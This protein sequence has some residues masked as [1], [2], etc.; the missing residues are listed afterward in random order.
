MSKIMV[1]C[2]CDAGD[3][4]PQGRCGAMRRCSILRDERI[5]PT[6][7]LLDEDTLKTQDRAIGILDERVDNLEK[8]CEALQGRIEAVERTRG[9]FTSLLGLLGYEIGDFGRV[10]P[11]RQEASIKRI[12]KGGWANV[13]VDRGGKLHIGYAWLTKAEAD[14]LAAGRIACIQIPDITE[15]DGL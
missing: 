6:I 2:D 8:H 14:G 9:A 15:G 1:K 5:P 4:C 3:E 7:E 12:Y 13:V 10:Q 11:K